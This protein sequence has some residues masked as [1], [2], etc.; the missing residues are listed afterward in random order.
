MDLL[1]SA[2][3]WAEEGPIE[4]TLERVKE[5]AFHYVDVEPDTLDAG[6]AL[7]T[8]KKLGLKVS[9]V[10]LDHK[11]PPNCSWES[12]EGAQK[13]VAQLHKAITKAQALGAT[14]GYVGPCKNTK[15]LPRYRDAVLSLADFAA[16]HGIKFCVEHAPGRALARARDAL[17][18]VEQAGKANLYLLL[19][20]GHTLLSKENA[21]EIVAAAGPRLGYVQLNDNDGK[22]DRHWPLLDG[23]LK[24]ENLVRTLAALRAAGYQG[25][26]GLEIVPYH[27]VSLISSFS[28]NHNLLLRLQQTQ[29]AAAS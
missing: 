23:I 4:R 22:K 1:P 20:V 6:N 13:T 11:L 7:A 12:V 28:K 27:H 14:T 10:A 17:A 3:I 29:T 9:C 8:V 18:F 24:E 19:D 26:L 5:T 25:T 15:L 16:G 2:C 21:W